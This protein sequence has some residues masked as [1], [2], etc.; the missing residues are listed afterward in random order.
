MEIMLDQKWLS[1]E[2][3]EEIQY[4]IYFFEVKTSLQW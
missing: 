2:T 4:E 1:F 3:K